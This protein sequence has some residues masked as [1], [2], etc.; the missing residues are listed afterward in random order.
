MGIYAN[1]KNDLNVKGNIS[2]FFVFILIFM[3]IWQPA[4][5]ASSSSEKACSI[6][7]SYFY[8]SA[9]SSCHDA[10]LYLDG[11]SDRVTPKL[12]AKNITLLINKYNTA[13]NE[14]L[15]LLQT[16]LKKCNVPEKEKDIPIVFFGKTYIAGDKAIKARLE[17]ELLI[18]EPDTSLNQDVKSD[19]SAT[20]DLFNGFK[21]FSTFMVGFA[22]GL[23]PCSLSMLL[24]F[25]SLLIARE[26]NVI[27]MGL[28]YCA[29]KFVTYF[30]LGTMLFET[31]SRINVSYLNIIV[32]VIML[33]AIFIFI[34]LNAMDFI[35]AKAENYDKIKLQLPVKLRGFNHKW[36]KAV[37]KIDNPTSLTGFSFFLGIITSIGEFLCTGQIYLTTILYVLHSQAALNGRAML[38]FLEYNVAFVTPLLIIALII[39][40]GKEVFD[41]SEFIRRNMHYIKLINIIIFIALGLFLIFRL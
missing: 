35:S 19:K 38:Y 41:V 4:Y 34:C 2:F 9:C 26:A 15:N 32:K 25:I 3:F 16:Y 14:N 12:K 29:G 22:N 21:V 11:V 36:I 10:E 27:K 23:T 24:F 37:T 39:Y 17:K 1:S 8:I 20:L 13:E 40:K 28:L 30:L 31:L 33:A 6:K 7:L 5:A 18:T